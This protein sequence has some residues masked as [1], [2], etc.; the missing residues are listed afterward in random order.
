LEFMI[1]RGE[2]RRMGGGKGGK[3]NFYHPDLSLF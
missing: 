1:E 3:E 2:E